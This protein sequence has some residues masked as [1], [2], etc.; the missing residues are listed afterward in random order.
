MI[1]FNGD[2]SSFNMKKKDKQKLVV[3]SIALFVMFNAPVLFLFDK[4]IAL[5]GLPLVYVYIFAIWLVSSILSF[6]IFKK[7][8]E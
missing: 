8:D 1:T 2:F 7:F 3:L 5:M 6:I 4:P